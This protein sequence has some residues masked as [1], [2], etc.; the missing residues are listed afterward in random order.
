MLTIYATKISHKLMKTKLSS[1][2]VTVSSIN[3][4]KFVDQTD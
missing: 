1:E 3:S 2:C 4:D